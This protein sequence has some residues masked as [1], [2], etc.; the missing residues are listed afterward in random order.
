MKRLL[1][2]I[3][4]AALLPAQTTF[5][6]RGTVSEPGLGG[7]AGAKVRAILPAPSE[8][9]WEFNAF[10]DGRG[11]FVVR[12]ARPGT[13]DI[14][15]LFDGYA[16]AGFDGRASARVDI[17]HSRADVEIRLVRTG[18]LMGRLLD[19][20]TREPIEGVQVFPM[21][22]QEGR[23]GPVWARANAIPGFEITAANR[24]TLFQRMEDALRTKKDGTFTI[25]G[26]MPGKSRLP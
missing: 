3:G 9:R 18:V 4:F 11:Q 10:T 5:E 19:A 23:N 1:L 24:D 26:V 22:K 6:I 16:P 8:T 20:E 17:D 15:A 12:T 7:I 14:S 13:Y 2:A 25:S 21:Q